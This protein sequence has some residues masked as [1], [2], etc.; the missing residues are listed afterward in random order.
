MS[1]QLAGTVTKGT[2]ELSLELTV[3]AG[4]VLGVLGPNGSG[5][6]TL[7]RAIAGLEPLSQG[8]LAVDDVV[9]QENSTVRTPQER[10]VGLVL[11]DPVL[12]PHLTAVDN[13][14]FGPRSRGVSAADARRRAVRELDTLGIAQ[15]A[16]RKPGALSTGQAQR[17][18]LARALATDPAVLLLDESLA[19]LDPQTRTS[20]RGV[21]AARLAQFEGCT[22]MVTHDPV[23]ALTLAE[24]LLFLEDGRATQRG[25]PAEVSAAPTSLYAARLVGLNLLPG[26]AVSPGLAETALG[27][28]HTG[29]DETGP[30]WLSIRPNAVSLWPS[31]PQGSPRN[32]WQVTVT[33]V[34]LLGQTARV[35]SSTGDT[36]LIAE[37]TGLSVRELGLTAGSTIWASVKAT[38]V[39]CYPR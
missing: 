35:L 33:G 18:A 32:A 4:S 31:R 5:K 15:F 6:T 22:L 30:V 9:W 10:E 34:E 21:L 11:A 36:Q 29:S 8:R 7:I 14:A 3:A 23:D 27:P 24:E 39:D 13:V 26:V 37:V 12:F 17:V 28:V 1:L 20:V 2:F 19:G 25:T 16:D 38:E